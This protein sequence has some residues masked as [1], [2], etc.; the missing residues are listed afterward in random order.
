MKN[1]KKFKISI[2]PPAAALAVL[3]TMVIDEAVVVAIIT[4]DPTGLGK[5]RPAVDGALCVMIFMPE[6]A[7]I[8]T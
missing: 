8:Y 7:Q 4:C 6:E 3:V 5:M 2:S 1:N